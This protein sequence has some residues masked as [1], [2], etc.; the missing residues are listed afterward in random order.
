MGSRTVRW[1]KA[2]SFLFRAVM[3]NLLAEKIEDIPTFMPSQTPPM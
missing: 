1:D 3:D 2:Q